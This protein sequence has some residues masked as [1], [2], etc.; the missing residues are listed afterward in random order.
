[1]VTMQGRYLKYQMICL[2]QMK[3]MEESAGP[4]QHTGTSPV[5]VC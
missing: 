1:M 5:F 2:L 3:L 4:Q